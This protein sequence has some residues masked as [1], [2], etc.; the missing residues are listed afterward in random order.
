[1]SAKNLLTYE[2]D[3]RNIMY[4]IYN[5]TTIHFYFIIQLIRSDIHGFRKR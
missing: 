4:R 3:S 5:I 1:M 2:M